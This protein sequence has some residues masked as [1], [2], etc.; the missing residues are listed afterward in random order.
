MR[1]GDGVK[2]QDVLL[3]PCLG[4]EGE[5][6]AWRLE[7]ARCFQWQNIIATYDPSLPIP[8]QA[9]PNCRKIFFSL[10]ST[11]N[12]YSVVDDDQVSMHM[13]GVRTS[14]IVFLPSHT[15]LVK[16]LLTEAYG[17]EGEFT[18]KM[19]MLGKENMDLERNV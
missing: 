15:T 4:K 14:T 9:P 2:G 7:K 5:E 1:R 10:F 17:E 3:I 13:G 12:G 16:R 11:Y 18:S 6:G 8:S 19:A